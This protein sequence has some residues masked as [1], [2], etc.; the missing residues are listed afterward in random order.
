MKNI[1]PAIGEA[2]NEIS[3]LGI[4]IQGAELLVSIV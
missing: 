1:W 2:R 4:A 3:S